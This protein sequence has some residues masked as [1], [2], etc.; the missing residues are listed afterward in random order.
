MDIMAD[1]SVHLQE[2]V[3][4]NPEKPM[5]PISVIAN[6]LQVHQRTLRIYDDENILVPSRSPKN[7]RLYSFND[8]EKGKFVQYLSRELGI[9]LAGIKIIF[10]LLAQQNIKPSK[11]MEH[12]GN[13]AKELNISP[14]TQEENRIKL[15]RRGRKANSSKLE[16]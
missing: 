8:I 7:R 2:N 6:I 1:T 13:V 4:L 16:E 15:S 9:N 10:H 3:A 12:I 5:F 14:E 11:Y